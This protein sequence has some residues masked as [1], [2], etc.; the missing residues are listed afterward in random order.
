MNKKSDLDCYLYYMWNA[1]S[2]Y[3]CEEIFGENLGKHIWNKWCRQ[4]DRCGLD[5]APAPFYA[6]LDTKSRRKIVERAVAHYN[7][8]G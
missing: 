2:G 4:C 7:K 6:E 3:E 1:W 8:Q 5:G